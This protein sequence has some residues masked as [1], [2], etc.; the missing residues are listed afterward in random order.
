M[1]LKK[2][3]IR[4]RFYDRISL[5]YLC[6]TLLLAIFSP[7][8]N[9]VKLILIRERILINHPLIILTIV[10]LIYFTPMLS[11]SARY[12]RVFKWLRP[13]RDLYPFF[14]FTFVLF[15]EFT[16]LVNS[17]FPYWLEPYLIDFD[18]WLFKQPAHRFIETHAPAWMIELMAFAYWSYYPL[19]L[20]VVMRYYL[21][22]DKAGNRTLSRR[23]PISSLSGQADPVFL[24]FMNRMCLSFYT[25]YVLFMLLPARSP[26][27]ALDLNGQLQ[28]AGGFFFDLISQGQNYV[29]VVGA[30][31]PSSHVAVAWVAVAAL[32]QSNRYIFFICVPVVVALT[33]SV[34]ILQYHYV[35]DAVG[36]AIVAW[37][38]EWGWRKRGAPNGKMEVRNQK[39]CLAMAIS[40][41]PTTFA[42]LRK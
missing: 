18:L 42:G 22:R 16:Y 30:A 39:H 25:C 14:L 11:Q 32:R 35:L 3:W 28:L 6:L 1:I 17:V 27:H 15:G 8:A 37:L 21:A 23:Q 41:D 5:G 20:F 40:D 12:R 34:F 26:R 38:I 36:G 2:F 24:D 9:A 10:A 31:F 33:L 29:S 7:P 13:M 19:I 4:L